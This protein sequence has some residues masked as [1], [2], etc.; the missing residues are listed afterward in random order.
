MRSY[1]LDVFYQG[2][3]NYL[4]LAVKMLNVYNLLVYLVV[5]RSVSFNEI[6][7]MINKF[8]VC[9][10]QG[11]LLDLV[12]FDLKIYQLFVFSLLKNFLQVQ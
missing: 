3:L 4:Q 9:F 2:L 1:I 10:E 6:R 5:I 7:R 11:M 8:K 12:L